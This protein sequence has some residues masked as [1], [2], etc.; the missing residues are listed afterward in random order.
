MVRGER[1]RWR[2]VSALS[3][4]HIGFAMFSAGSPLGLRAPNLRQG[5]IDSLDSLHLIRGHVRLARRGRSRT[6]KA[7]L[8]F[9][10][11]AALGYTERLA[12]VRFMLGQV[13]LYSDDT[14]KLKRPDSSR[15]A[16]A[17]K[18]RVDTREAERPPALPA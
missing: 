18:S 7:Y 13:G 2:G 14:Y 8:L 12:R 6:T 11:P 17:A 15:P 16:A 10:R 9:P 4:N 3:R 1:S 5:V